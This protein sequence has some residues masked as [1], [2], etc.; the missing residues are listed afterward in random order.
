MEPTY[1]EWQ[2]A[3]TALARTLFHNAVVASSRRVDEI[4][5]DV[6]GPC[7]PEPAP[8]PWLLG[9]LEV[10]DYP[11]GA[12]GVWVGF[13][14]GSHQKLTPDE[15]DAM[16][17]ALCAHAHYCRKQKARSNFDKAMGS[18]GHDDGTLGG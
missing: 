14:A 9:S 1:D 7:P 11:V 6:L 2:A 4:T 18:G 3:R 5:K 8:P 10:E 15:A 12:R 16:A 17:E 13:A